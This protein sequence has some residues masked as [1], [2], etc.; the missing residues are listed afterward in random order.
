MK[1]YI[2]NDKF[3]YNIPLDYNDNCMYP[4]PTFGNAEKIQKR[5]QCKE[6]RKATITQML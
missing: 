5:R 6:G 4:I 1:F 3:Q 2:V